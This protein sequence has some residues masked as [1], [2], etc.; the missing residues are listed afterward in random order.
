MQIYV[1]WRWLNKNTKKN[2]NMKSLKAQVQLTPQKF[3]DNVC[4]MAKNGKSRNSDI[5]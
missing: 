4:K 2:K 1:L 3:V 5:I